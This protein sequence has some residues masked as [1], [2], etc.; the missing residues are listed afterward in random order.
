VPTTGLRA[1]AGTLVPVAAGAHQV[2]MRLIPWDVALGMV[3]AL[4]AIT[5]AGVS[6]TVVRRRY[7]PVEAVDT[8]KSPPAGG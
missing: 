1:L 7:R 6:L 4:I 3:A 8:A 2:T 5:V